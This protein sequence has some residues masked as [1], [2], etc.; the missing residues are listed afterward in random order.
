MDENKNTTNKIN[1]SDYIKNKDLLEI[2][3]VPYES[4]M[5]IVSHIIDGVIKS[6]GGLNSSLLR[7]ISDEV[8]IESI[9]NLDMNAQDEN[10]L[11]GFDQL[12]YLNEYNTLI[13]LLGNEYIEFKKILNEYVSDYIRTE[14][15]PAITINAIYNQVVDIV[16]KLVNMI[17]EQIQNIDMDALGEQLMPIVN[18][19]G[20]NNES[21]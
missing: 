14:T 3:Y 10:G 17:S 1:V 8:I 11:K 18:R 5:S 19:I 2:Q 9:T 20:G 21:K 4:K 6:I 15:N 13:E 12:L 16:N 7:M